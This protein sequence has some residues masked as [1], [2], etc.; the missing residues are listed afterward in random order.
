[1]IKSQKSLILIA[2]YKPKVQKKFP[3]A[4]A[5]KL[6]TGYTICQSKEDED[7]D[8]FEEY[9]VQPVS[10]EAIAWKQLY[11]LLKI[12]QN[13]NRTHPFRSEGELL[14]A[15][16]SGAERRQDEIKKVKSNKN[17]AI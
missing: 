15:K 11:S 2:K 5:R 14:E 17:Y 13:L 16:F 8:L 6:F 1:M 3:G 7:V 4:F 9:F 10:S 12:T